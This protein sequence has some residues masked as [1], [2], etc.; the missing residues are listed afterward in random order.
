MGGRPPR[1]QLFS[2]LFWRYA[3]TLLF[4][5]IAILESRA[6][7]IFQGQAHCMIGTKNKRGLGWKSQT[8]RLCAQEGLWWGVGWERANSRPP[9]CL[10]YPPPS[11]S[12]VNCTHRG[13]QRTAAIDRPTWSKKTNPSPFRGEICLPIPRSACTVFLFFLPPLC[14]ARQN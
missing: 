5:T 6:Y 13:V 8:G 1:W 14:V 12:V 4:P 9:S 2:I 11:S 10:W 3:H 7:F